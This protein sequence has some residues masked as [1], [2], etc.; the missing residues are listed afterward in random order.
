MK[1]IKKGRIATRGDR[2]GFTLIEVL[3][4]VALSSVIMMALFGMFNSVVDVASSVKFQESSSYGERTFEGILFDDLRSV[5][6][7]SGDSFRFKGKSGSF[8]GIDGLLMEFC[9]TA[10]LNNF[11]TSPSFSLQRVEYVMKGG[12]DTKNIYRRERNNCGLSG[13]WEWV[14]VPILKEISD[15]E[16]E[17]YDP[18]DNSFVTE[19]DG[20]NAQY[21]QAVN[22]KVV[23]PGNREHLFTVGL[24][25]M[26][27]DE[28]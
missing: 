8:L 14:E 26:V 4:A 12:S 9:S 23:Y 3:V 28:S 19:W 13:D 6:A 18:E 22:V 7:A 10:S 11:G 21:P 20:G 25:A 17:Y 2:A 15:I 24:S 5:Y 27:E 1:K 16:I